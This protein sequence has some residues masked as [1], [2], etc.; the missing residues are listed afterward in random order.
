MMSLTGQTASQIVQKIKPFSD[1]PTEYAWVVENAAG[2]T[3]VKIDPCQWLDQTMTLET[4]VVD[5]FV[6][7]NIFARDAS[8]TTAGIVVGHDASTG[9]FAIEYRGAG[10]VGSGLIH[11]PNGANLRAGNAIDALTFATQ[12]TTAPIVFASGGVTTT[13]E[14]LRITPA[15]GIQ[16]NAAPVSKTAAGVSIGSAS[17]PF[18]YGYLAGD[19]STPGTNNFKLAGTATASRTITLPDADTALAGLAVAQTF[20][21][22]QSFNSTIAQSSSSSNAFASGASSAAPSFLIDNSVASQA[23]GIKITGKADGTAPELKTLTRVQTTSSLAGNGLAITADSAV[24]GSS[25]AGAAAGGN[26]TITAGNAGRLTSGNANG[27]DITLTGGDPVG[28]GTY[29]SIWIRKPNVAGQDAWAPLKMRAP[30]NETTSRY[31]AFYGPNETT[32]QGWIG[33]DSGHAGLTISLSKMI[34]GD[35]NSGVTTGA[36]QINYTGT[37]GIYIL[38][39]QFNMGSAVLLAWTGSQPYNTRDLFLRRSTSANLAFGDVDAAAPVAQTLSVQNV[40]AGTSNTAGADF[41]IKGSAGTGTGATGKINFQLAGAAGST[42][43]TQNSFATVLQLDAAASN[44]TGIIIKGNAT[45]TGPTIQVTGGGTSERLNLV[46]KGNSCVSI[47]SAI[48]LYSSAGNGIALASDRYIR[49]SSGTND[50]FGSWPTG[51]LTIRRG[52]AASLVLGDVDGSSPVAQTL[53][54]QNASGTSNVAGADWTFAGSKG[55]GTGSGGSVVFQIAPKGSTGS[56]QNSLV[57]ALRINGEGAI[58]F[59]STVTAG[60]TTGDRTINKVSG[61]VNIAASGTSVT[62]TNSL[63]TSNSIVMG[64]IRTNDSTATIKNIVPSSGSFVITL[65]AAATAETSIGF[66]VI[67]Q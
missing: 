66:F 59:P 51:D 64:V 35:Q 40:V 5:A 17:L 52:A 30:Q 42:S 13:D 65:T 41:T 23:S 9:F 36:A 53:S 43:S 12:K 57:E 19:S 11:V 55:T 62:V 56:T 37:G 46:A 7:V 47:A 34:L 67:N 31:I 33:S 32:Q 22:A 28:T 10:A 29:G 16:F 20:S 60:G 14:K 61:T 44:T 27:G 15:S 48:G 1:E 38:N 18:K 45:G 3:R 2:T 6:G 4:T 58:I 50:G 8:D 63:V 26:I 49:W 25:V 24:A 54:V 21:A 39:N